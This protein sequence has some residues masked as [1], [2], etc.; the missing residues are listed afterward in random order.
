MKC[1]MKC[2]MVTIEEGGDG[3]PYATVGFQFSPNGDG[4]AEATLRIRTEK[5]DYF[6]V[7]KSYTLAVE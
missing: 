1:T 3:K 2:V 7:G 5:L 4:I 6:T